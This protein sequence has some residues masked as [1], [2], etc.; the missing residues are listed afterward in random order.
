MSQAQPRPRPGVLI[1]TRN[2]PPLVGGMERLLY[3]VYLELLEDFDVTLCGPTGASAYA[4]Q[5]AEVRE[6]NLRPIWR[7]L[8]GTIVDG[9]R[10]AVWHRPRVIFAGSGLTGLPALLLARMVGAKA[11][12]YVHGLDIVARNWIY[13]MVFL[14]AIR[15]CDNVLANSESTHNLALEIGVAPERV[16][17]L[18]PGVS[19]RPP[20]PTEAIAQ[21][22]N[23]I[24]AGERPILLSVGRLTRRKG[25]AEFI[26]HA[27]GAIVDAVPDVLLLIVGDTARDAA[28]KQGSEIP[29]GIRKA[30][31]SRHLENH[32]IMLGQLDEGSLD[33]AYS[34]ASVHVFPIREIPG[35]VEGFGMV[36]L[37]AA[38]H[39]APTVAFRVGGVPDAVADNV[40]GYL[41]PP[42]QYGDFAAMTIACL[43]GEAQPADCAG[44]A[45][46]FAW[47]VF[48]RHLRATVQA[49]LKTPGGGETA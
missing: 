31:E 5:S 4:V 34:A 41:I 48:G 24:G 40:S 15:S 39:G 6:T 47:P 26:E 44:F 21:F 12:V 33:L 14:P 28:Q 25:L 9:L 45:S 11:F 38:A 35:D 49:A 7:F 46:R 42:E 22:R 19:L 43:K 27:Y 17:V 30:I 36:A 1:L 2:F 20:P 3:H 29:E 37:E 13:R 16:A 18:H 10:L 32:V 8:L 23:R